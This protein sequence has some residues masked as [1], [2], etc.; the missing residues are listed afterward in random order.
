MPYFSLIIYLLISDNRLL[1]AFYAHTAAL[2]HR[3]TAWSVE[4][5][6]VSECIIMVSIT[7]KHATRTDL[8]FSV[9]KLSLRHIFATLFH[10][11]I[12]VKSK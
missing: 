9:D 4:L 12:E 2:A 6:R 5:M 8:N 1:L 7:N 3:T 10:K 11:F